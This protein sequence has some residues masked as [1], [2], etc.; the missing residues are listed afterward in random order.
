MLCESNGI[1]DNG[2]IAREIN[3]SRGWSLNDV[4]VVFMWVIPLISTTDFT[5]ACVEVSAKLL[6]ILTAPFKFVRPNTET[7]PAELITIELLCGFVV[8]V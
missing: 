5:V 3:L 1:A 7:S 6:P 8:P 4:S 2:S